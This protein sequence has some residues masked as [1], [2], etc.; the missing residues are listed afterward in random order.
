MDV[1]HVYVPS[2]SHSHSIRK[3]KACTK[4]EKVTSHVSFTCS[5]KPVRD[6]HTF[7]ST[8]YKLHVI[9]WL[10]INSLPEE[11]FS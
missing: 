9:K 3:L 5:S 8:N 11:S 10:G 2:G 4:T 6:M 7:Y 1:H